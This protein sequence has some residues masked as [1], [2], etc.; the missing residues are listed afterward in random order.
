M[1]ALKELDRASGRDDGGAHS[2][3]NRE[4]AGTSISDFF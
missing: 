2:Q 4:H 3:S 1:A